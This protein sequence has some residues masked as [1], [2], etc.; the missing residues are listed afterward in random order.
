MIRHYI[1]PTFIFL[2]FPGHK[3]RKTIRIDGFPISDSS[4]YSQ[5]G[6]IIETSK[7]SDTN[8]NS[9]S[10]MVEDLTPGVCYQFRVSA[11]NHSG[12]SLPSEASDPVTI[13]ASS[14]T[15]TSTSKQQQQQNHNNNNNHLETNGKNNSKSKTRGWSWK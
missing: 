4:V 6:G 3:K 7:D 10:A 14:S 15:S 11:H 2:V 12:I 9:L 5:Y 13:S 8:S 1:F